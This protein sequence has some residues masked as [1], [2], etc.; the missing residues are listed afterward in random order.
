MNGRAAVEYRPP[1]EQ[2]ERGDIDPERFDHAAHVYVAWCYLERFDVGT[3]IRRYCEALR[4]LTEKLGVPGKYHET[5]T[6]FFVIAVAERR[7]DGEGFT[8]FVAR[9]PD[10]FGPPSLLRRYY[11]PETLASDRAR[12][13]FVLPDRLG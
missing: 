8:D 3:T 7:R 10:L 4:R 2:F 6:W 5:I 13:R 1:V 9:N 12:R 11:R